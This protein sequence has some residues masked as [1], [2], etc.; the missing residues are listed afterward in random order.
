[1]INPYNTGFKVSCILIIG[2][3]F[4]LGLPRTVV[5][6]DKIGKGETINLGRCIEIALKRHPQIV[7][8][9]KNLDV[10]LSKVGQSKAGYYPQIKWS[11][12]LSRNASPLKSAPYNEYSSSVSLSQNIFDFNKK[13][14][15]V[16]IETLNLEAT[17]ADLNDVLLKITLGVKQAYYELLRA[18]HARDI[19]A[20]T[21]KQFEQHLETAKGLF[22]VGAKPKF[23]V[24]KAEV[25]LSN[26]RINFL[27]AENAV[28]LAAATLNNAIGM[29]TAPPY[30]L[31]DDVAYQKKSIDLAES[32]KN[33]YT[34]RP[35]LQSMILKREGAQR[36]VELAKKDYYP[37]LSGNA[38]YGW[39]GQDYPLDPGWNIGAS[40]DFNLFNGFSTRYQIDE[41]LANLEVVRSNED[42]LR[43]II[44]LEVEQSYYNLQDAEK[45]IS[46]A[47]ITVRQA[48]ENLDLAQGRYA[49][50]VGNPLEVTDGLVVLGNAKTALS[51]AF[52]DYKIAE[53]NIAK[54]LG[55]GG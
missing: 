51:G 14:T 32:L 45:R 20:E 55:E 42:N 15:K 31:E 16:D 10:G 34:N 19:N 18:K 3:F 44:Q 43:Q 24:T 54:A 52:Y 27:K 37:V 36:S 28:S 12:G 48:E 13:D 30:D 26:A 11:T 46:V 9:Q 53:A 41:A 7:A 49:A 4:C 1:M 47:E 17:R 25:D 6:E 22:E 2:M 39:S 8:S 5:A 38:G 33:A 29:P 23:D 50:G 35:D 21:V 40:L